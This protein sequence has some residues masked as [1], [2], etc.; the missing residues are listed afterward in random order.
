M[1][2]RIEL[3]WPV[4]IRARQR[5]L[6]MP[7]AYLHDGATHGTSG[8]MVPTTFDEDTHPARRRPRAIEAHGAQTAHEP[9]R[10][11]RTAA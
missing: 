9:L 11:A 6:T 1:M 2:R 8:R 7:A 4:N 10:V 3:A 5:S